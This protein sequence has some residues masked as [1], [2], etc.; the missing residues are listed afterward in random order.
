MEIPET[1]AA[2]LYRMQQP[3]YANHCKFHLEREKGMKQSKLDGINRPIPSTKVTRQT[4]KRGDPG[5]R[6]ED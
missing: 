6:K 3:V 2:C 5:E 1:F 4:L